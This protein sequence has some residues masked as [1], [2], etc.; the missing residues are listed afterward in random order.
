MFVFRDETEI[1]TDWV[2]LS[3]H[4][5]DVPWEDIFELIVFAASSEF[6][7]GFRLELM[8]I[9]LIVNGR[10]SLI[11]FYGFQKRA[12]VIVHRNYF[13]CFYQQNKSSEAKV[14]FRQANKC[15]KWVLEPAR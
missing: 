11:Y 12:A 13:F 2:G 4:L 1:R 5:R 10:S 9:S 14:K 7:E 6:C 15:Y 3:D 8:Y